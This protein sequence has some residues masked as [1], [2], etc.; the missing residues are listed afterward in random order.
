MS[1][2]SIYCLLLCILLIA[3]T[4]IGSYADVISE[5]NTVLQGAITSGKSAYLFYNDLSGYDKIYAVLSND[6]QTFIPLY[7]NA[8]DGCFYK[9]ATY[10]TKYLDYVS[11]SGGYRYNHAASTLLDNDVTLSLYDQASYDN[12]QAI[13]SSKIKARTITGSVVN[14]TYY[15][16][17]H[18]LL[19][20]SRVYCVFSDHPYD[21]V[22]YTRTGSSY[23]YTSG[24]DPNIYSGSKLEYNYTPG[25][26]TYR[27]FWVLTFPKSNVSG[28]LTIYSR[29]PSGSMDPFLVV[30]EWVNSFFGALPPAITGWASGIKYTVNNIMFEDPSNPDSDMSIFAA[31]I[32]TVAGVVLAT[33]LV[34]GTF[35]WLKNMSALKKGGTS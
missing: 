28:D 16:Y 9:E 5:D 20:L 32:A 21:V 33:G 18:T 26:T 24:G 27:S 6:P 7:R 22:V 1:K 17:N 4:V 35:Y 14:S 19:S 23:E 29:F 25:D 12:L 13:V 34:F 8:S 3:V 30:T 2:K 31:L 10:K 15:I 11:I